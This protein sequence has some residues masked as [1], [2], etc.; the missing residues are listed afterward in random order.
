[1]WKVQRY[2]TPADEF[3]DD[4]YVEHDTGDSFYAGSSFAGAVRL[5]SM[6]SLLDHLEKIFEGQYNLDY[7]YFSEKIR[8]EFKREQCQ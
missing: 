1:M 2:E 5:A 6:L 8:E 7:A 4:Y 3:L